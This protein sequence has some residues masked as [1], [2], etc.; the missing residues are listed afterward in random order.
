MLWKD[1]DWKWIEGLLLHSKCLFWARAFSGGRM[2]SLATKTIFITFLPA[3]CVLVQIIFCFIFSIISW[4]HL[5]PDVSLCRKYLFNNILITFLPVCVLVQMIFHFIFLITVWLHFYLDV[6]LCRKCRWQ[7]MPTFFQHPKA[8]TN[9]LV[10]R[11]SM[12][13]A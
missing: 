5:Y 2:F 10:H 11:R 9:K 6:S 12:A 3:A 13:S 8:N 7:E 1:T 4:L